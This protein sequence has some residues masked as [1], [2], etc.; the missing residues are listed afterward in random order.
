MERIILHCDLNNF[1]ASVECRNHPEFAGKPVAVCGDAAQRHGIVLAKNEIAKRFGI[2]TGET[3][4][5]ARGK[6]PELILAEPHYETYLSLSK[7]VQ[8]I[9]S[10]YTD[11][12]EPFGI[13]E[14]WLD[15]SGSTL[16]F[17]SGKSMADSIRERV[18]KEIG[19][20][21]SAGV[22]FNKVFAKMGSDMKKPDGTTLISKEEFREKI[23][24]L[25]ANEMFGIGEKTYKALCK[26]RILTIGDIASC[27]PSTMEYF[28]GKNGLS[29]W[30]N[31]NGRDLSPV[32]PVSYRPPLKSIS[33]SSTLCRDI[34]GEEEILAA[35]T[36]LAQDVG[37][38]LREQ[39]LSAK[40]ICLGLRSSSLEW[41]EYSLS[42]PSPVRGTAE[43]LSHIKHIFRSRQTM[44]R[45][46]R[47]VSVRVS[48]L[49]ADHLPVQLDLFAD[50]QKE[51]RQETLEQTVDDLRRKHGFSCLMPAVCLGRD[52]LNTQKP[53]RCAFSRS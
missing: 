10:D 47:S 21:V 32:S 46:I 51:I 28:F 23:W 29:M 50:T 13:D 37:Q 53:T 49:T 52:F 1:F 11:L 16:L 36:L 44:Q 42:L 6:C 41:R 9:Y 30:E 15:V 3:I 31:A 38:R 25:P 45:D 12:V 35:A 24:S 19:L 14:C 5:Q 2:K 34:T 8:A 20:T 18:K 22:S 27:K 43:I 40:N 17:G 7:Q 4:W 26:R 33:R 39:R 48:D